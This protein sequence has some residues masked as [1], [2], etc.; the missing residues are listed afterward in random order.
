[1]TRIRTTIPMMISVNEEHKGISFMKRR[2]AFIFSEVMMKMHHHM[3]VIG[4]MDHRG[5]RVLEP[6]E[7]MA[8]AVC[9]FLDLMSVY[10]S[11]CF[12]C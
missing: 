3:K 1:M 9:I 2:S 7:M 8:V 5:V 10:L 12:I 6:H 4:V 11:V